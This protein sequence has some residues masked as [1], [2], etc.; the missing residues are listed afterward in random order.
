MRPVDAPR[1]GDGDWPTGR[2]AGPHPGGLGRSERRRPRRQ[3]RLRRVSDTSR[4]LHSEHPKNPNPKNETNKQSEKRSKAR[5]PPPPYRKKE[6]KRN[7][8]RSQIAGGQLPG[9]HLTVG[10]P[11]ARL[12]RGKSTLAGSETQVLKPTNKK[13]IGFNKKNT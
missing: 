12:H 7:G 2:W 1:T 13:P 8:T 4:R 10:R 3:L 6:T 5:P 9:H 11:L